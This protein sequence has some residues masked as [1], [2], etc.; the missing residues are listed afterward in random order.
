MHANRIDTTVG[1]A[2]GER[3]RHGFED[4]TAD[5]YAVLA[6]PLLRAQ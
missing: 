3:V 5:W 6:D 4:K 1:E 2:C